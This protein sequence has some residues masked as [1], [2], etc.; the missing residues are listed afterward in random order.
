MHVFVILAFRATQ[1]RSD[2]TT[3]E[4][5]NSG[6]LFHYVY[7]EGASQGVEVRGLLRGSIQLITR[8]DQDQPCRRAGGGWR[9]SP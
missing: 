6:Q 7:D 3:N 2:R 4:E 5:G 9:I 1:F 8:L